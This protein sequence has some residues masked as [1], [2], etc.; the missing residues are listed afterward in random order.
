[1][2]SGMLRFM[3]HASQ[4]LDCP[5]K[6]MVIN[7]LC[8][9]ARRWHLCVNLA[10]KIHTCILKSQISS[11]GVDSLLSLMHFNKTVIL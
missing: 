10:L 3:C 7:A 11:L 8:V 5:L 2:P 6:D 4:R 9:I 1:M